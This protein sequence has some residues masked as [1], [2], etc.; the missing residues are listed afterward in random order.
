MSNFCSLI[1][2]TVAETTT[3]QLEQVGF[4]NDMRGEDVARW[5]IEEGLDVISKE[6]IAEPKQ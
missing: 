1:M 2:V 4:A 5:L 3:R 6:K